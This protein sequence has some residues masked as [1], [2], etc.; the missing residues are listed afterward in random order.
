[1][2]G[3][4]FALILPSPRRADRLLIVGSA[5]WHDVNFNGVLESTRDWLHEIKDDRYRLII[6]RE[7]KCV[8]PWTR[9]GHDWK[10]RF[11]LVTEAALHDRQRAFVIRWRELRLKPCWDVHSIIVRF[12]G[13]GSTRCPF[14]GV[15]RK[16]LAEGQKLRD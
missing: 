4:S 14:I 3:E 16:W 13:A 10:G 11:P 6:Q 12:V 7:G 2:A 9:K 1:M 5:R 8:R 15:D